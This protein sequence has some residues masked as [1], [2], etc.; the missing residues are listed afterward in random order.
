MGKG[1]EGN[2]EKQFVQTPAAP[3]VRTLAKTGALAALSCA[4]TLTVAVPTP[5]G[6]YV[7][8]GDAVVLLGAYLLG[9]YG[10]AAGAL[11]PALADLLGGYGVYAPATLAIKGL[12]ALAAG[13]LYRRA[14]RHVWAVAFCGAAAESIMVAGY[15]LYD[16]L[17]LGS[18]AAGAAGVPGNLVQGAFGAACAAAGA[19]ALEKNTWVRRAFPAL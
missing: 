9:G 14:R 18:L 6:G 16:A 15:W 5:T 11:G 4:A 7:N 17:L 12:M 2:M 13:K 3:S 10:A 8:P 1:A 19:A